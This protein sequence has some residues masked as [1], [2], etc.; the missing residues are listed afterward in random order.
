M[1]RPSGIRHTPA[2]ASASGVAPVTS[3]PQRNKLPELRHDLPARDRE[4]RRLPG[5]VRTEQR[6]H[7]AGLQREVDAVQHV[8]ACRSRRA[9]RTARAPDASRVDASSRRV[10]LR[11]AEVRA[12][13]RRVGLD[14]ARRAL[15]DDPAEVE[16]V[17]VRARLH[18]ER[19]VVL[20]E[21]HA[22]PVAGEL[23]ASSAP[24][25]SVSCSSSPDDGSSSSSTFGFVAS[26]RASSTRRAVPVGSDSTFRR[27]RRE[28]PDLFEQLVGRRAAC[29]SVSVAHRRRISSATSTFSRAVRLPNASSRWNVRAMPSRARRC[30]ACA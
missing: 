28:M 19:H 22:E 20:D 2:R 3:R 18:H 25:A 29:R 7:L 23:D 9:P 13:H 30:G 21:Q 8:D 24:S 10:D 6:E 1:P 14:L 16:H 11:G 17:D 4:R 15:R 5:A 27:R 26:A 12:L